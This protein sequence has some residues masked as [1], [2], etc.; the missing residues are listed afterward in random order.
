MSPGAATP[1]L[2]AAATETC[3]ASNRT[4]AFGR[5][6]PGQIDNAYGGS[7]AAVVLLALFVAIKLIM[8]FNSLT[9]ARAVLTGA[10][11]MPLEAFGAEGAQAVVSL[12]ML[13]AWSQ[14]MLALLAIVVLVR[15]RAMIPLML[16]VLLIEH[17]GRR[18]LIALNPVERSE[19]TP[20]GLYINIGLAVVLLLGLV[21]SLIQR[22]RPA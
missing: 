2:C 13:L 15:Y 8:S 11:A 17:G 21:L 3:V 14:L 22:R 20:V 16:L 19:A 18:A 4:G 1:Y 5:I 9:N 12:F 7:R 10:D 6:F